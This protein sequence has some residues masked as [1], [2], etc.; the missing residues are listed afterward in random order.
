[1]VNKRFVCSRDILANV[2]AQ[3]SSFHL[4][5]LLHLGG[6]VGGDTVGEFSKYRPEKVAMQPE[7]SI[8]LLQRDF[9]DKFLLRKVIREFLKKQKVNNFLQLHWCP[10]G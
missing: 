2:F 9:R 10:Q 5:N 8:D 3:G 1:M 7:S 6:A 4:F